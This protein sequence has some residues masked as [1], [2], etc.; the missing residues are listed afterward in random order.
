MAK[1]IERPKVDLH[2]IVGDILNLHKSQR[3][4]LK[5]KMPD[6]IL[7]ALQSDRDIKIFNVGY[8]KPTLVKPKLM[9]NI[10]TKE[11]REV[12]F[13]IKINLSLTRDFKLRLNT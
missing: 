12:D 10:H 2:D 5:D 11:Y 6:A 13:K 3:L 8:I 1:T 9:L 4:L 7:S